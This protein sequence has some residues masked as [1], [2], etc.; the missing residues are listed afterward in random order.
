ML[1]VKLAKSLESHTTGNTKDFSDT[2]RSYSKAK[3]LDEEASSLDDGASILIEHLANVHDEVQ[4]EI[5]HNTV[6][7]HLEER[8]KLV[9]TEVPH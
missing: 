6:K 3:Q 7:Q 9:S 2:I 1:D 8:D 5:Y 4:A